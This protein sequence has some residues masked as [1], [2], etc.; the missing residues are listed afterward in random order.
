MRNYAFIMLVAFLAG[1]ATASEEIPLPK[2]TRFDQ[3][4]KARSAYLEAYRVGYQ[5]P[6]E[7]GLCNWGLSNDEVEIA[8]LMGRYD[9]QLAAQEAQE[10]KRTSIRPKER[11]R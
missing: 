1:C 7:L 4:P 9:G 3:N 10:S 6:H 11:L 2:V 5:A 8:Q